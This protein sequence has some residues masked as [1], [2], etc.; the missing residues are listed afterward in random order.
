M[1]F[2]IRIR[3]ISGGPDAIG[4]LGVVSTA[5]AAIVTLHDPD[6]ELF[7]LADIYA[8]QELKNKIIAQNW[9]VRTAGNTP[10]LSVADS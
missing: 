9:A 4:T 3:N 7:P 5:D 1:S 2:F 10:D 8:N 6:L